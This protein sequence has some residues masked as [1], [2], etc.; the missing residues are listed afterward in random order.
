MFTPR[1]R[2][3]P[4][5][6]LTLSCLG[7]LA[8]LVHPWG[9]ACF[10]LESALCGQCLQDGPCPPP[11]CPASRSSANVS[12]ALLPG[13]D[14]YKQ[15]GWLYCEGEP[16]GRGAARPPRR[17]PPGPLRARHHRSPS[18]MSRCERP[19]CVHPHRDGPKSSCSGRVPGVL[20]SACMQLALRHC[21]QLVL[22]HCRL[23]WHGPSASRVRSHWAVSGE[24]AP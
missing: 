4:P 1:T 23:S 19:V 2:L 21:T 14:I 16:R 17:S 18:R 12:T 8:A 20:L 6:H 5:L 3:S 11:R 13:S 22:K 7:A 24:G 15:S 10:L 9:S